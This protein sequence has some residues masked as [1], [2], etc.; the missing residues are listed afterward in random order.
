M[1]KAFKKL[2]VAL[3]T[4]PVLAVADFVKPFQV[5]SNVSSVALRAV[6]SH[7]N[8]SERFI[9]LSTLAGI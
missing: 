9:R 3:T 5:K 7:K 2:K 8:K 1:E 4:P 6:L